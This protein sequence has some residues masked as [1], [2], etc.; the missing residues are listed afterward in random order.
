M[1]QTELS[2]SFLT[3]RE[4][5]QVLGVSLRTTQLWVENGQLDAWKTEGGHRRISRASVYSKEKER[6]ECLLLMIHRLQNEFEC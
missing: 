2:G 5:A 6:L 1:Q 3:T 4:A